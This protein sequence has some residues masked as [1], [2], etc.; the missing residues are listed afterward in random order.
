MTICLSKTKIT[1]ATRIVAQTCLIAIGIFLYSSA[2][3][4]VTFTEILNNKV[5]DPIGGNFSPDADSPP[6]IDG[7]SIVFRNVGS[8]GPELWSSNLTG[9]TLTNLGTTQSVLPGLLDSGSLS[10]LSQ[11][12]AIARNGAVL[13][14]ASDHLCLTSLLADCGGIWST[15]P[16][17]S[18]FSL[19]VNGGVVDLSDL[20]D[21]FFFG[22]SAADY[23]F[24]LDDVSAKVA[25]EAHNSLLGL[26]GTTHGIYIE[27]LN[28]TGLATIAD[29][30]GAFV[31]HPGSLDPIT[32][33]FD[34]AISN[35]V[36]AFVGK[37]A[38]ELAQGIYTFPATGTVLKDGSPAFTEV[39]SS[40]GKLPGDPNI[41][42]NFINILTPTLQ[43]VGNELTFV[44]TNALSNPTYAGVFVVNTVTGDVTK[45]VS[46]ADSLTGLNT[47]LPEFTY[48]VNRLGQLVFKATDGVNAGYFLAN[49]EGGVSHIT[50]IVLSGQTINVSGHDVTMLLSDIVNL[51]KYQLSDL[52]NFVF[53]IVS[54]L[55]EIVLVNLQ[56][57]L[58]TP[59]PTATATSTPTATGTA[60]ASAT[61][62]ATATPTST[63]SASNT[64]TATPTRTATASMTPT[65]TA[66]PTPSSTSTSSSTA[67]S[68][69]TRTS[70]STPTATGTPSSTASST[71]TA[72]ATPTATST[73]TPTPTSTST[74]TPEPTEVPV[75]LLIRP[76]KL[77]FGDQQMT[78]VSSSRIITVTNRSKKKRSI[79]VTMEGTDGQGPFI[80]TTDHCTGTVLP[81]RG[82]T[83]QVTVAFQP[84]ALGKTNGTITITDNARKDPQKV[85]LRGF[86]M[87]Q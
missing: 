36:V 68:T 75:K 51:G 23:D 42:D 52:N 85:K 26:I 33:F 30:A 59:T 38:D 31:I 77:N 20:V 43:L 79:A 32:D 27:N 69:A 67:T 2:N 60:K 19:I 39:L 37:S 22:L 53:Q 3:A 45:I 24:A 5:A 46:T 34:P 81:F 76:G 14:S 21:D 4:Q 87:N 70:T 57:L 1:R 66:T 62:T 78:T 10:D 25:F 16:T 18:T 7:S 64:A 80:I 61:P 73:T 50:Q 47:L 65:Q 55:D 44:A 56:N 49:I 71:I 48:S 8:G 72:T 15:P 17:S 28:G 41:G 6:A 63:S 12:P 9:S 84:N 83:C 29:N 82:S 13:F 86:G 40:I 58:A 35:G 54:D 74:P 11:A